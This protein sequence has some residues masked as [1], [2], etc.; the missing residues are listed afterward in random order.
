MPCGPT[1]P[2]PP[3]LTKTFAVKGLCLLAPFG[4]FLT[5]SCSESDTSSVPFISRGILRINVPAHLHLE[6]SDSVLRSPDRRVELVISHISRSDSARPGVVLSAEDLVAG[7]QDSLAFEAGMPYI[8][9]PLSR[10]SGLL[11]GTFFV[12]A[13][14]KESLLKE[15]LEV[16]VLESPKWFHIVQVRLRASTHKLSRERLD[17]MYDSA[18]EIQGAPPSKSE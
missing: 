16:L 4:W 7:L 1:C 17:E 18:A 11:R 3:I 12:A 5:L 14:D 9:R 13:R 2:K 15:R 6:G 8:S 10:F